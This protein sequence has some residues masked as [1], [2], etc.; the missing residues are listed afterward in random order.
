MAQ[1][2]AARARDAHRRGSATAEW[3]GERHSRT[4]TQLEQFGAR[5]QY[6]NVIHSQPNHELRHESIQPS[7]CSQHNIVVVD[8]IDRAHRTKDWRLAIQINSRIRVCVALC[9]RR[10][11]W[12]RKQPKYQYMT[13]P[14]LCDAGRENDKRT[15]NRTCTQY[16]HSRKI[17]A[18]TF[19]SRNSVFQR[20]CHWHLCWMTRVLCFI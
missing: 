13:P 20:N 9:V 18:Y 2:I 17:A 15:P 14:L 10:C 6:T 12:S 4:Q 3:P 5:Q 8:D 7:S 1:F 19:D 11:Q 16:R